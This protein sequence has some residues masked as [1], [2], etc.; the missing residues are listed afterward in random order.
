M[1]KQAKEANDEIIDVELN[2]KDEP[3]SPQPALFSPVKGLN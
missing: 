2:L 3:Q 1:K